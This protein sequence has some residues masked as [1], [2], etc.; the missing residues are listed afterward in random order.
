[1][2]G[3]KKKSG[4]TVVI[5][6]S[7]CNKSQHDVKKMIAGPDVR[8]CDEC[9]DICMGILNEEQAGTPVEGH[10]EPAG[11]SYPE[12]SAFLL[13]GLCRGATPL[14]HSLAV[15]NRGIIC[16]GCVGEIEAALAE[17]L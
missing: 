13:C 14:E 6:C 9:V 3:R 17:R 4:P 5:R 15:R 2:F 8:I 12:P 1:M 11:R 7:F 10:V 16:A